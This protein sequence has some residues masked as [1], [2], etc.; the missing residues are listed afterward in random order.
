LA[1]PGR[2]GSTALLRRNEFIVACSARNRSSTVAS[3]YSPPACQAR[4]SNS[5]ITS[6]PRQNDP[7]RI[8]VRPLVPPGC[9]ARAT[10]G[11][12]ETASSASMAAR[13]SADSR[14]S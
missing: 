11:C 6:R 9:G 14:K 7:A 10:P 1:W 13:V 12:A 8:T 3:K 2:S 4:A 5:S